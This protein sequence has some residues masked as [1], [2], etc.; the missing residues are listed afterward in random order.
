MGTVYTA[1]V[2]REGRWWM[3]EVPEIDGLTQARH[4]R[5]AELMARELI[6]VTLG[7]ELDEVAVR[8]TVSKIGDV[9]VDRALTR[10]NAERS[11]AVLIDLLAAEDTRDLAVSLK[12]QGLTLR[13]I[14]AVLGVSHQRVDQILTREIEGRAAVLP[15]SVG[16]IDPVEVVERAFVRG[17]V[18]R[19]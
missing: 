17:Q 16:S 3:V 11:M 9:D 7:L 13:D 8:V 5:E 6:A 2:R 12:G 4:L 14:G 1:H 15:V 18:V 19:S 10:I